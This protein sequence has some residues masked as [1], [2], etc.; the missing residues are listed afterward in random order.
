[1]CHD[2]KIERTKKNR[3]DNSLDV[4]STEI[5][6]VPPTRASYVR[7]TTTASAMLVHRPP[8]SGMSPLFHMRA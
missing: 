6:D 3:K 7:E 1:M 4:T 8:I 5:R 2:K